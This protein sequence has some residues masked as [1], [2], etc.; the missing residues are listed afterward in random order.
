MTASPGLRTGLRVMLTPVAAPPAKGSRFSRR[1]LLRAAGLLVL[2]GV[3]ALV[4]LTGISY[5]RFRQHLSIARVEVDRGHNAAAT[6]HLLRCQALWFTTRETQILAARVAR[7]GGSWEEA[8]QILDDYSRRFGDENELVSERLMLN[9][10]RGDL[11]SAGPRLT[12]MVNEGHP[13]ARLAREA[14]V[15]GMLYRFRWAEA[16]QNVAAWLNAA[17][18]DPLAW[19]LRG[20]LHEQRQ[21]AEEALQSYRKVLELDPDHDEARLR[22]TTLLLQLRR[23]EEL[24]GHLN[25]LRTRLPDLPEVQIQW[26]KALAMQGRTDES[27]AALGECLRRFPDFAPALLERGMIAN[28]AGDDRA[29]EEFFSRAV[30]LAPGDYTARTHYSVVLARNGKEAEAAREKNA[31]RALQ[32]DQE[33]M[34]EL[35]AGPLQTR[36]NDPA[37]PHEIA[38]I[39]LRSGQADE[40]LRWL[41][42]ALLADPNHGPTHQILANYYHA[43]GSPALAAKHRALARQ[44]GKRP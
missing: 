43:A 2:L 3:L 27:R 21:R 33:R 30:R 25:V 20:K 29:A 38:L 17:P 8:E 11:T 1:R 26:V 39:A 32:A 14:I 12:A 40:G 28:Q 10:T 9:A 24:I 34:D 36:P 22:A 44:F 5:L 42:N 35:I 13:D 7:R 6:Q 23:S 4:T 37:V 15:V 19:L 18:D 31:L 41:Q 16:E